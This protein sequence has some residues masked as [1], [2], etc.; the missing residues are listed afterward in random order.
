[1][2]KFFIACTLISLFTFVITGICGFKEKNIK[3]SDPLLIVCSISLLST[4]LGICLIYINC[5]KTTHPEDT[6]LLHTA[7]DD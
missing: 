2:N 5:S 7:S 4:L 1:M 3:V 6:A